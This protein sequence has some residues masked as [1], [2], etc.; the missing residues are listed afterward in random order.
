MI[1]LQSIA[2]IFIIIIIFRVVVSACA[3]AVGIAIIT[4][5]K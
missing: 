2:I 1:L 4:P 5:A 3:L